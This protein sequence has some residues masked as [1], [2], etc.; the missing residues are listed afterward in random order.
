MRSENQRTPAATSDSCSIRSPAGHVARILIDVRDGLRQT[1][2]VAIKLSIAG[3]AADHRGRIHPGERVTIV[4]R[5]LRI[6]VGND[7]QQVTLEFWSDVLGFND[8]AHARA[9]G[10]R[11][12][13]R[14][15]TVVEINPVD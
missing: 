11:G 1:D 8:D 7:A 2:S 5:H 9:Q 15:R 14:D 13:L 12:A 4:L 10:Q 3:A 6:P